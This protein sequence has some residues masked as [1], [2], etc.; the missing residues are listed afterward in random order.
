[1]VLSIEG[2]LDRRSSVWLH[3]PVC[4]SEEGK[5]SDFLLHPSRQRGVF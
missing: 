3:V 2:E 1:M 5:N 4:D